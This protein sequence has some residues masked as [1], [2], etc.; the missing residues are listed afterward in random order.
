MGGMISLSCQVSMAKGL[1]EKSGAAPQKKI[2]NGGKNMLVTKREV[3]QTSKKLLSVLLAVIM[4]MTSMSVCFGT[5]V[6]TASA[7]DTDYTQELADKLKDSAYANTVS[8]IA[9]G[10]LGGSGKA[11]TVNISFANYSNFKQAAEL[12]R[13]FDG[14]MKETEAWAKAVAGGTDNK[15]LCTGSTTA[16]VRTELETA[17]AQHQ[18][19]ITT[20]ITNILK[21]IYTSEGITT[22]AKAVK[23]TKQGD[24]SNTVTFT[25]TDYKGY[26]AQVGKAA[27]VESSIEL[28]VKYVVKMS[29][30]TNYTESTS[31]G[32][33]YY[34][35]HLLWAA[36]HN[37]DVPATS[38]TNNE[39]KSKVNAHIDELNSFINMT[40]AQLLELASAGS[41]DNKVAEYNTAKNNM[42][43][44]VGSQSTYDA[45]F[46]DYAAGIAN[47]LSSVDSAKSFQTYMPTV[48]AWND[49]VAANP[50]YGVF[51]YDNFGA[52]GSETQVKLLEDFATFKAY[53]DYL[54]TGGSIYTYLV[55]YNYIDETYYTNFYDNVVAYD[56]QASK[57][58]ADALYLK[59][60]VSNP[61]IDGEEL[62]PGLEEKNLVY[63]ELCGYINAIGSYSAQVVN[64]VY[65][66]GYAYLVDLREMLK[67]DIN[68]AVLYFAE[69][70]DKSFTTLSTAAL[71]AKID[72][73]KTQDAAL[74]ALY[75]DVKSN[76]GEARANELLS[77][78]RASAANMIENLYKTLADRFTS[79]VNSAWDLY[80]EMGKPTA[81]K[82]DS[83]LKLSAV[84]VAIE[85]D[86]LT[87]LQGVGKAGYITQTTIDRYNELMKVG[88]IYEIWNA[89]ATTFGFPDYKQT[90]IKYDDRIPMEG[91]EL[92]TANDPV[93]EAEMNNLITALDKII[94]S[95]LVGDLLGGLLGAAEG[96]EFN[97]GSMLTDLIKGA[98][99]TDDF[100]NTVVQMLYPLVLNEFDKVWAGLPQSI[101]YSG[102]NVVVRYMKSLNNILDEGNF[103]IFPNLLADKLESL[104]SDGRYQ[105][106]VAMLR[107]AGDRIDS[108][109]SPALVD[110]ETGK[111][112]LSWGVTEQKEKLDAGEITQEQFDKFFYQAFEDATAGLLPLL[113]TLITNK[114]WTPNQCTDIATGSVTIL[115]TITLN[116][117]L[118]LGSTPNRG[119][120]NM[121]VPIY[122]ILGVPYTDVATIESAEH[123]SDVAYILEQILAPIFTFLNTLGD[124][125]VETILG[126][127]PN[128]VYALA[129]RMVKPM[130]NMLQTKI[131]YD[132]SAN[133]VGSVMADGAEVKVGDMLIGYEDD[134]MLKEDM[135]VG[136][137]N[138]LLANFGLAIPAI[139]QATLA[140]L[141]SLDQIDTSRAAY[142]YSGLE[143]TGKAYS[144][145]ADKADVG[146]YLL[147]YL[148]NTVKDEAALTSLLGLFMVQKDENGEPILDAAGEKIPDEEAMAG[149]KKVIYED[150]NLDE[151]NVGNVIAAIVELANQVEYNVGEY[152][153]YDG[154][155]STPIGTT[156]A[157]E[158]YLNP[159][160]DWT[161]DKA[162]YLYNNLEGLLNGV[163]AMAGLDLDKT[164]EEVDGSIE[165]AL[166]G[167]INGL[168]TN[169]TVT[170]LAK[171]LGS[172]SDLNSLL[173]PKDEAETPD[174]NEPETVAEGEEAGLA[175]DINK[176]IKDELGI[177]LSVYAQY[178]EIAEGEEIDFGVTDAESFIAALTDLLAPIK[179]LLD[180]ILGGKDLTL[181]DSAI[182][183]HG[184]KGYD[185]A[186]IPL[187]EALGAAPAAYTEGA[188]TLALTLNALLGLINKLTTNDPAVEK[189]GAIYTIIDILP[190]ILYYISSNALSQ[191]VDKLLTPVYAILDTIRPIYNVNLSELLAGIEI[192]EEGNKKPLGLDIKNITWSFIF[193]LLNDLLGLDLSALQQVIY[194]VSKDIGV[195]YTSVSTLNSTWKKGAYSDNFSQ[196]DMLTVVLSFVLEWA[197][198]PANAAKLDELLKTD[199]I[200]ASL[201]AVFESVEI[202][203]GTPNWMYWFESE[204]AFNAYLESGAGLPNTLASL[205]YPSDNEWNLETAQYFAENLDKLVDII[206]GMI[207]EG[208]VDENGEALPTTL[209]A[210][211]SDLVNGL[212]NAETINEL[213]GMIT[214][215]LGDIDE[216][217]INTA[218]YLLDVDLAGLKAYECKTE[219]NSI[220]AFIN[221]LA[222]VLDTYAGGLVNWLFFGDDYRFAKKSDKTDTIVI[223]GG[224]GYEKGL[225]M[226]I[227]AL[228]CELPAEANT[229]SVLGALATRVEAILANPVDEVLGLLPNLVYFLNANGA[230][231]AVDNLLQPVYALLDKINGLGLLENPIVLAD[232]LKITKEDG[233]EI[234][235]DLANLSLA[236]IVE[237]VEGA[238]GLSL[239]AAEAI[240]VDFCTGKITKGTYIYKMEAAKED[241]ITILLVV[242]LELISDDAFATKLD[243][244]LGTDFIAKI[245]NIFQGG[246]VTYETPDWNYMEGK[247]NKGVI[248]YVNAITSYPNDWT[249][250]KAEYLAANLP[251]LVDTVIRMVE[252]GGVKYDS[253][254]ALLQAN[255]NIFTTETLNSLLDMIKN[256]LGNID[257]ELL[258]VGF[259]IDVDLEGLMTYEVPE[260]IDTVGEFADELANVLTTYAKGAVEWLLL[261][262][263][264]NLLV[265]DNDGIGTGLEGVPYI[266][267]NGAQGYA[268]GLALLLEALGC[269][270]LPAVY[271]VEN[272]DTAATV[273]AVLASLATRIDE[274]LANPV[275]EVLDLLPNLIYF[276]DADGVAV[277][278]ENTTAA[279]MALVGKLGAFGIELDINSLV[280]LPELMGISD[281]YAEGE[282]KI[283]L[284]NLTLVALLKALSL[285]TDLD[286]T[287]LQNVLV[288]FALG[289][290]VAYD[291]VSINEE[292]DVA[293]KM[294]YKT[295]YDKHDMISVIVTAAL[296]M[297]VENEDNAAKL[298]EM[299][300][301]EI[302]SSL[303]DVFADV[304]I[305]YVAPDWNYPLAE[306]G[307]VDAMKY[308]ITYPNN[309]TEAT[310]KYVTENLPAIVDLVVGLVDSNYATL[311]DLLEDKVNVFTT[312]NLQSIV[313]LIANLL[314]DIDAGL[315]EAAGMLLGADVVGL[316]TYKAPE[317]IDT[318]D[319]FAAELANVLNTYAKG[320]VEW[321]L[322]GNDYTF[323]VK[324]VQNGA[325]VDFITINGANGYAEGLA[326]LLEALGCKNL[327]A[328]DGKTE[329]IVSG[330]LE[331]LAAR[332]DEIFA[333]PV[334]EV[335][336]VLPNLLYFLNANGVAAVVDN[337]IAAVTALLEKLEAFGINVDINE[338]VNIKKLMKLENTDATISL[339]DL[340]MKAI[341]E[342]VSLMVG[343]DITLIEDVLVGFGLGQVDEY[344][345]I[346]ENAVYKMT[347]KAAF[348]KYDMV[349]VIANL[350]VLTIADAD[351]AEFV[352]KLAGDQAY[353]LIYNICVEGVAPVAVQEFSWKFTEK[354]DTGEAFSAYATSEMFPS[355]KYGPLYTEEMA[356]YIADNFGEFVDN[357]IYLLGIQVIEGQN[358]DSLK[359]LI[360]D[361]LGGSL[362]NSANVIAI[363]DALAG[364]LAG[365]KD[366]EVNGKNVGGYI[367]EVLA[368]SE[369]ADINAVANVEVPE[370]SE[371]RAQFVQYL[372]YVLEPLY[373]VLRWVLSNDNIE[374]FVDLDKDAAIKLE[375]GEGY[376]Y[377]IIPLL[378]VLECQNILAPDAYY[379]AV[380]ADGDVVLTSILNPLLDRVDEIINNDPAQQILDM[381]PNLIYFINSNGVDTV[382]RNTLHAV[383]GLLSAIAPIAEIDLYEIIG[384]D[385]AEINFEW[386]FNKLLELIADATGYKFDA[387]TINAIAELTVGKLE[388]YDSLSGKTAYKMVY[389]EGAS[390]DKAE[391]ATI[392]MRLLVTFIMHNNNRE[393]LIG[394]L[395]D[396]FNMTADAEKY[397]RG[398]LDMIATVSVETYLGMDQALAT[399]YYVFYGADLGVGGVAGGLKDINAEWQNILKEL[400]R[401]DDPNEMTI[402]NILANF[403]DKYLDD[404]I[405]EEGVAPNGLIAFFQ[406][407]ADWFNK[408]I[409][410]FKNLF[411]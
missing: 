109:E 222:N 284:D 138:S 381:L 128:L 171:L 270:N 139:D 178:A 349:T 344:D 134:K 351:N 225:A 207:N 164:T 23:N 242:A 135:F 332:I 149:I 379:A 252:I 293:Y 219:I 340:S 388:S 60:S 9:A 182:T 78:I 185:N 244:M 392:V 205:E 267:L 243:E 103:E 218:G 389:A 56:L 15:G 210:L 302:V 69:N 29:G 387:L 352:K 229:K 175:I 362:Y 80:V 204:D 153:W 369:I 112:K 11:R 257:A 411:N 137:L 232:L 119:Y 258:K 47:F 253:L 159:G 177:D 399:L 371:D 370:F 124:K 396:N 395:K 48:D 278:I 221:E 165:A 288:P 394:L 345:S 200:I 49:F 273:E 400:G 192:G 271:G 338:L 27:N 251:A 46:A 326:L 142:I 307:T 37:I 209:S 365:I 202:T 42:V 231:V 186:I 13:L 21:L 215:L 198:V 100:I 361:L 217:L 75:N 220:S 281:K 277:V 50:D 174:A 172:L 39:V 6:T 25:T 126:I 19:T 331:S 363:R 7:E 227:E 12:L 130:L 304:E 59:Y 250:E 265:K 355:G 360:N 333:N 384:I 241:V 157:T 301:T 268:E 150:L 145:T 341:L 255:V 86:I 96:E 92:K 65:Y 106:N 230:G 125:P 339:D 224:Y 22:H 63:S 280:N 122:E 312:A 156:S 107:A 79:E 297:F 372:C 223:N 148:L 34:Y 143:G 233:T 73:A 292:D 184:Y 374:F 261:G 170:A 377:G 353:E 123:N 407:I 213:V 67:C 51:Q 329:E 240:L 181:I 295:E 391:M 343:L 52:A 2:L 70:A 147:S 87:D 76:V 276:L 406:K 208:K 169:K 364:V 234:A 40:Y 356:N 256:L 308:S 263:D 31:C 120:A 108:W 286:F 20:Q 10:S 8:L 179:P 287:E 144:I 118:Q 238:T 116:V 167:A 315:L 330:V 72:E 305:T 279:L 189:D 64:A 173:A 188:D 298:D 306:N 309:W 43:T 36:S 111:L 386:I 336:E 28:G 325:P 314:T 248:E 161:E 264:F 317:G 291:S 93:T 282:E 62:A 193:G 316:R 152:Y 191:G 239:D 367:A 131:T 35:H 61:S 216:N 160:N 262:R 32:T 195:T 303:K 110:Y 328:A 383:Y 127:L 140:T 300:G 313:D 83:F 74:T 101:E 3:K 285:M 84:M 275:E 163:F 337:T 81:L 408:I 403:M 283:G 346:S 382:V 71:W 1:G 162:E 38:S 235:I 187:L 154:S 14:A 294:V 58:K 245:K 404:I 102:M 393:L 121:L 53:R 366:L 136:G 228:G 115:I 97:L 274:I 375:G 373:P 129:F 299:L 151:M 44:Y 141:G 320:V 117:A 57:D 176:I 66:D 310:A 354:A 85:P 269:E 45:I 91:D 296:R 211:L 254:A 104:Y 166:E 249:E 327:P 90:Q 322:L 324:E 183:L 214:G 398:I 33:D 16:D 409:E 132:A 357:I 88:G 26:L 201:G 260:G 342:A 114:A 41:I 54:L 348:E 266:T 77:A 289:E 376:R 397:I 347:Y 350:V 197:T 402:G 237:I 133:L 272:L 358:V 319:E 194:D 290:A 94:T 18:V 226:I 206:I 236:N 335:V 203:Y 359:D 155:K 334:Y 146:Y 259:I 5:F 105:A 321:L 95:D 247:E 380:E 24:W 17:L 311:S 368:K 82:V 98:L 318:A 158:I 190:G 390:G 99:F 55:D 405:T 410:W 168:F 378:E 323:F 196:A 212:V 68:P 4:M 89:Y 401:S 30:D 113:T 199:G 180:F 385:L 246:I